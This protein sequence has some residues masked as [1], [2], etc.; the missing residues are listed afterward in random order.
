MSPI[1]PE[2]IL[3]QAEK[4]CQQRN[5]RLTPQR[6]EVLRLM[7]EQNGAISAYDLLDLL[8]VSEPQAKPPT[9]YRALDFLLEQ[10]F[11][12]RVE[13]NNSYVVCHHVEEPRHTSAMLI[14]DRCGS[15]DE[16]HAQGVEDILQIL[17]HQ[18]GFNLRHSIIE[19]HGLCA[20]CVE[21]ESCAQQDNCQHDHSL[22]SKKRGR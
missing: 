6:L 4:L 16:R 17:S 9:V 7:S 5:V 12:H 8:R 2:Q 3:S 14:C 21:V 22:V 11:I 10:G 13:S 15:V 1:L 18:S 20:G 19:A